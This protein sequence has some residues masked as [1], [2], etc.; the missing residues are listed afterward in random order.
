[1]NW[2]SECVCASAIGHCELRKQSLGTVQ[3]ISHCLFHLLAGGWMNGFIR[4]IAS[5]LCV[6]SE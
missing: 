6:C 2:A 5:K 1:M 3:I 4:K